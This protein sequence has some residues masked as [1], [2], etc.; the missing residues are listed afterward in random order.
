MAPAGNV[1]RKSRKSIELKQADTATGMFL[2]N[3]LDLLNAR[4]S[5]DFDARQYEILRSLAVG[6][7]RT[8]QG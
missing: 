6:S 5:D 1:K 8:M 2:L 4:S 3:R 7:H